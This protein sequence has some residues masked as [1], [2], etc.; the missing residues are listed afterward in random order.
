MRPTDIAHDLGDWIADHRGGALA[1]GAGVVI[2]VVVAIG[3]LVGFSGSPHPPVAPPT[4]VSPLFAPQGHCAV[5]T[6]AVTRYLAAHPAA[7]ASAADTRTV[8]HGLTTVLANCAPP[9]AQAFTTTVIAPWLR[10]AAPA[11]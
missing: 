11:K 8:T 10:A 3:A 2:A 7:T 1:A 5:A 9:V 6:T 4:A